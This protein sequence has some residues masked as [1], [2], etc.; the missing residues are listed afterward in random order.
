MI[1]KNTEG[2]QLSPI[3]V[4]V[5]EIRQEDVAVGCTEDETFDDAVEILKRS[6]VFFRDPKVTYEFSNP[7]P[8]KPWA[9]GEP[10]PLS[11][12]PTNP[13]TGLTETETKEIEKKKRGR[14]PKIKK[15]EEQE[16]K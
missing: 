3:L 16:G 8:E 5:K 15:E 14:P 2:K 9:P 13:Q 11:G 6:G 4:R 7:N 1:I 12:K 10:D